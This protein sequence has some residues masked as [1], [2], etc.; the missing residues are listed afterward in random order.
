M[1]RKQL[2]Q[3]LGIAE[4]APLA[5]RIARYRTFAFEASSD[6]AKVMAQD[7]DQS[8]DPA[9]AALSRK[10]K[11]FADDGGSPADAHEA[12]AQKLGIE[13][14][15]TPDEVHEALARFAQTCKMKFAEGM[16]D[17]AALARVMAEVGDVLSQESAESMDAYS[18]E[19]EG[20]KRLATS[21]RR[22]AGEPDNASTMAEDLPATMSDDPEGDAIVHS[23]AKARGIDVRT[24]PRAVILGAMVAEGRGGAA[25]ADIDARVQAALASERL[26]EQQR[27]TNARA[28]QLFSAAVKCG[29]SPEAKAGFLAMARTDLQAAEKFVRALP[30]AK[31]L[32][33]LTTG[34]EPLS[35][36]VPRTTPQ[37][38]SRS[39]GEASGA[40]ANATLAE[41]AEEMVAQARNDARVMSRLKRKAG[42]SEHPGMLLAAAQQIVASE[43]PHDV[44]WAEEGMQLFELGVESGS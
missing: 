44:E 24:T 28:E 31:S 27:A 18:P 38:H 16:D 21:M 9:A 43:N 6:E 13:G 32:T 33:R 7:L 5:E 14:A 36:N 15:A 29:F 11:R 20:L 23:F 35:G 39:G 37:M 2:F 30:G 17:P 26:R 22:F 1:T 42:G 25:Q 4:G 41:R 40:R 8:G 10:L 34:G 12:L 3:K 19:F